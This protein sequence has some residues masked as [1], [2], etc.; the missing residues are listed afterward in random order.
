MCDGYKTS[1]NHTEKI[2]FKVMQ[3]LTFLIYRSYTRKTSKIGNAAYLATGGCQNNPNAARG[4][5]NLLYVFDIK[6]L[7]KSCRENEPLSC[8]P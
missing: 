4:A 6:K 5:Q 7:N 2:H 8:G 1:S 3:E